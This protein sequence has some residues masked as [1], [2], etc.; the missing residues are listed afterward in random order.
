MRSTLE[1]IFRSSNP[2]KDKFLSRLF[3]LFSEDVVRVW[4]KSPNAG[5]ED[6]GRPTLKAIGQSRGSTLDFTLLGREDGKLFVG[7]MK[8]ELE[9]EN[10]R[11]LRLTNPT[12]IQH[13]HIPSGASAAFKHFVQLSNDPSSFTVYVAG[14]Q[15]PVSGTI[16]VWGATSSVGIDAAKSEYG[17]VDILLVESMLND[18]AQ[19]E[20][21]EWTERI[22]E[23]RE[24][25]NE[26]FSNLI[27][28]VKYHIGSSDAPID[29]HSD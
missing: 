18:L 15:V 8:A 25:S 26:L 17:F 13:H 2:R 22:R 29:H 20:S 27:S 11:Y 5:Y 6:I 7:E 28:C 24:W 1:E 9:F 12:Q 23:L 21:S 16:L 19:W 14:K 3:G 4:C 10:Y